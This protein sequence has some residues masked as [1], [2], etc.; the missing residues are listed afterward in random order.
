MI[1]DPQILNGLVCPYCN[2][3]SQ[4]V[5]SKVIY[6]TSYGNIYLCAPCN[7]YVGTHKGDNRTALGRLA[8]SELRELKKQAHA[9]FD[10][11]WRNRIVGTRHKAYKWLSQQLGIP[12]EYTHIGMF[13]VAE[14]QRVIDISNSL[15]LIP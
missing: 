12:R 6:G 14:C 11:L 5:D 3:P 1:T 8:N 2:R 9:A 13:D 10:P 4:L 7:A 15:K